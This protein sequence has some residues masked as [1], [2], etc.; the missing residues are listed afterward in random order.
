MSKSTLQNFALFVLGLLV[1]A[2][3]FWAAARFVPDG[4]GP[5]P[6]EQQTGGAAISELGKYHNETITAASTG[7]A[8]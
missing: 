5:D 7:A 6:Q 3:A 2:F 1:L 8:K 4:T